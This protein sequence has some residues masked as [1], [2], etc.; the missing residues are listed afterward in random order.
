MTNID[1]FG[2]VGQARLNFD[3]MSRGMIRLQDIAENVEVDPLNVEK[4]VKELTNVVREMFLATIS[5]FTQERMRF[6]YML[7]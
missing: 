2:D 3:R 1:D 7:A 4:Y 6:A 5:M